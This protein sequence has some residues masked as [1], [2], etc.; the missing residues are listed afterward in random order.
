MEE[1]KEYEEEEDEE[2]SDSEDEA[3]SMIG[4]EDC[5]AKGVS[6]QC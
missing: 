5:R 4:W 3:W 1:E 2:E 6:R